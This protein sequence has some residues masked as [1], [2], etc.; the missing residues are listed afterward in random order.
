M[1][2]IDKEIWRLANARALPSIA[3]TILQLMGLPQPSDMTATSLL[4]ESIEA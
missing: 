1:A 2:T 3:P 4:L